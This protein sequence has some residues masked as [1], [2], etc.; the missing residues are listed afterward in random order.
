MHRSRPQAGR[1]VVALQHTLFR[2]S[3]GLC[4][5]HSGRA[6]VASAATLCR[7]DTVATILG[8]YACAASIGS[9]K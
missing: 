8:Q 3:V 2:A 6:V 9:R 5:G 1:C 7:Y 4:F